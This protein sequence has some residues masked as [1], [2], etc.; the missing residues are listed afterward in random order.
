MNTESRESARADE[1]Y[2]TVQAYIEPTTD[3]AAALFADVCCAKLLRDVSHEALMLGCIYGSPA[4]KLYMQGL[5]AYFVGVWFEGE[6]VK[7]PLVH[8]PSDQQSSTWRDSVQRSSAESSVLR[9]D[10][11]P[12]T[13]MTLRR[14]DQH[15]REHPD[16]T[17]VCMEKGYYAGVG[18]AMGV[19][20]DAAVQ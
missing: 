12:L 3:P 9:G 4:R 5:L 10:A 6:L 8:Q 14:L 19:L 7:V 18:R 11:Y 1:L 15:L 16:V 20:S 2:E 13:T 17:D